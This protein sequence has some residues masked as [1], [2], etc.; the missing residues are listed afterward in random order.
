MKIRILVVLAVAIV[1]SGCTFKALLFPVQGPLSGQ[2]PLP[3]YPVKMSGVF[4]SGSIVATLGGG[5]V[6]SGRITFMRG[7]EEADYQTSTTNPAV[8]DIAAAWD[9]VYGAGFYTAHVL[10]GTQFAQGECKSD[11]GTTMS[12]QVLQRVKENSND[13]FNASKDMKGVAVDNRG[14]VFKMAF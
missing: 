10:G 9:A 7:K 2:S 8:K 12:F 4:K 1:L 11:R 13:T 14:N 3:R 6:C 5:E